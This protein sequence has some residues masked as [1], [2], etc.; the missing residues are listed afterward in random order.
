MNPIARTNRSPASQIVER[1][2]FSVRQVIEPSLSSMRS[3]R[4]SEVGALDRCGS[5]LAA[6]Y[7]ACFPSFPSGTWEPAKSP[8][9]DDGLRLLPAYPS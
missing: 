7:A 9:S 3:P 4:K 6:S 1:L 2:S 5:F 8:I